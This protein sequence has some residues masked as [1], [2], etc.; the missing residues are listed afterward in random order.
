[1]RGAEPL[2]VGLSCLTVAMENERYRRGAAKLKE[3]NPAGMEKLIQNLEPIAPDL[4]RYVVEF[5]YGDVYAREGLTAQQ[6]ELCIVAALTAL[7]NT[8]QQLRDHIAAARNVGCTAQEITE[9]I[10]M[11]A[12]YAGFPVAINAMDVAKRALSSDL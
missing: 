5:A 1:M 9:T 11:M 2:Y 10:L 3:V 6:R 8:E 4:A 12:V 7:G